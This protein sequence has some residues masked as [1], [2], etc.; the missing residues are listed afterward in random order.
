MRPVLAMPFAVACLIASSPAVWPASGPVGSGTLTPESMLGLRG[1]WE[2][3]IASDGDRIAYVVS[4][5][6]PV[7]DGPGVAYQEIRVVSS[8]DGDGAS[9]AR[10]FTPEKR[11]A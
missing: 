6:R 9:A 3:A 5:P 2:V 11:R 8:R 10:R 7:A 4:V 1:I